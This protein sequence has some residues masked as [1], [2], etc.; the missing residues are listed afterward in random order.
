[1]QGHLEAELLAFLR[2]DESAAAL[3]ARTYVEPLLTGV[4][5]LDQ[6]VALRPGNVMEVSGPAGSG[7]TEIL[8]QVMFVANLPDRCKLSP[9]RVVCLVGAHY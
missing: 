2:P 1:M 7:K 8:V 5:V 3:L 4:P 9:L 6:H